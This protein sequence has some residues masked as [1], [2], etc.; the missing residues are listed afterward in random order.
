MKY[1]TYTL[2]NLLS[3]YRSEII[4]NNVTFNYYRKYYITQQLKVT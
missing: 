4:T 3:I 1:M 2:R